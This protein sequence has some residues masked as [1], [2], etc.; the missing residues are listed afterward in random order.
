MSVGDFGLLVFHISTSIPA[1]VDRP[2]AVYP[3]KHS[4][5]GWFS[6]V[7]LTSD[8]LSI[9]EAGAPHALP[10]LSIEHAFVVQ[11]FPIMLNVP[12]LSFMA[13]VAAAIFAASPGHTRMRQIVLNTC[14]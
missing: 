3:E 7:F 5:P 14:P 11:L 8:G 10:D 6:S 13:L 9:P 12:G 1:A 4:T 2:N